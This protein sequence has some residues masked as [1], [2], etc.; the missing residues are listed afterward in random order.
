MTE[1]IATQSN[2]SPTNDA[3]SCI[4][5]PDVDIYENESELMLVADVPGASA[6]RVSVDLLHSVLTISAELPASKEYRTGYRRQFKFAVP[7]DPEKISAELRSGE[8]SVRIGKAASHLPKRI[9]V[10]TCQS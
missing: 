5:S 4:Y 10:R 8:L 1:A 6:D 7:V 2:N 9:E 3:A